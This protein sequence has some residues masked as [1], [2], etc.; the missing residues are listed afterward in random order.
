MLRW[1]LLLCGGLSMVV[2]LVG[3]GLVVWKV[4]GIYPQPPHLIW[5]AIIGGAIVVICVLGERWRYRRHI[6]AGRRWQPTG[7]CFE[8]P[9]TGL[10]VRVLYDPESGERLYQPVRQPSGP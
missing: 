8:D 2:G 6:A 3:I 9:E 7:E 1:T 4:P 10:I 5:G